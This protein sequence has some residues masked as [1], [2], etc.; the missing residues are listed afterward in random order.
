MR[1]K[2]SITTVGT[3]FVAV[4]LASL[5]TSFG[6]A[7][8]DRIVDRPIAGPFTTE[9]GMWR[10]KTQSMFDPVERT[11]VRRMYTVWDPVPSQNLDF[12]WLPVSMH[13]D[14]EG[15]INGEGRLVWRFKGRP[16]YE[17]SSIFAEYGGT[18]KNGRAEGLGSYYDLSGISYQGEWRNGL[19]EGFGTLRLPGGD[20]Y[21]G[22]M[23]VGKANG[24]GRYVDITGEIFEGQFV[25]GM[26]DGIGT[27]TLPNTNRYR[28]KWVL[29]HETE[30]SR[31]V[32]VAESNGQVAQAGPDDIRI[33]VGIDKT[34]AR[35]GDLI[36]AA[37][38]AGS[39][40]MIQPDSRRLMSM[41]KGNGEIQLLDA[42][43]GGEEY[44]VFSKSRGEILPLTLVFE[45]QNRSAAPISVAG[46][47]LAVDSSITDLEPAI[48]LNRSLGSCSLHSAQYQST[49]KVEN[50]GWGS[51]EHAAMHFAF[52]NPNVRGVPRTLDVTKSLGNIVQMAEV[53]LE[54]ELRAAGVNVATLKA[55]SEQ[56]FICKSG[57]PTNCLAQIRTTGVFGSIGPQIGLKETGLFVTAAGTLDYTWKDINGVEQRRSSPYNIA[58]PL[59]HIHIEAECGEGGEREVI[60]QRPLP[61]RLDQSGYR[62]P[63][64]FQRTIPAGRTSRFT[65][66]LIAAKSSQHAFSVVLQLADGRE[67]S[68][69]PIDLIYFVP[70]WFPGT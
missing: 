8:D 21:I 22:D 30:D 3:A 40:L 60:A 70:S 15:E 56:G 68:S 24:A 5:P 23:R 36:Y 1:A 51:A 45:V 59:G 69:R 63:V 61:F 11:V 64:S 26:R 16:A 42:E 66:S 49:F 13:D 31:A 32:R 9:A 53:D 2:Q 54:P 19:M 33:G 62:L 50:F 43:E 4:I 27:T 6:A 25:D 12:V 39:K 34:K 44:G 55:R 48:Q 38:S 17:R 7:H 18:M 14:H 47:Y 58:L 28:S 65:V 46:A 20:E 52:T 29:G 37:S 41:W 10:T 67:I 57:S 35:D